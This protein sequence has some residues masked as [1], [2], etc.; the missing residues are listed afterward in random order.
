M[1]DT[2]LQCRMDIRGGAVGFADRGGGPSFLK[3]EPPGGVCQ[4]IGGSQPPCED[5][6]MWNSGQALKPQRGPQGCVGVCP[7]SLHVSCGSREGIQPR[8]SGNPVGGTPRLWG[9]RPPY[10]GC[11]LSI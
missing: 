7:T 2:T 5:Q 8:P 4:L 6:R 9:V 10:V 1:A 11:P 3:G